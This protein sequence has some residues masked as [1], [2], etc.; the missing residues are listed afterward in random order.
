MYIAIGLLSLCATLLPMQATTSRPAT[1]FTTHFFDWYRVTEQQPYEAM[2][3]VFTFRPDW[4]SVGL[5]PSEVGVSQR[6]YS[7]QFRMIQRAGFD[8]IHYEWF[9][10]QPSDPCVAA[11]RETRT[12]AA[13]FYDQEIRFHG[14]PMFIKPTDEF[15]NRLRQR[16]IDTR[17]LFPAIS[18]YPY[19]PRRQAPQ[20]VADRLGRQGV[21]LPSGIRL[22][23]REVDYICA[24]IR[25]VLEP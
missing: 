19:W 13:M 25:R 14:T 7:V 3:R 18:R 10:A 23:R 9:G 8:G 11:L 20:P 5:Q 15:R 21:N 16:K 1:L 24:Q 12:K 2:Q 22:R 17:P 4:E 6:Y